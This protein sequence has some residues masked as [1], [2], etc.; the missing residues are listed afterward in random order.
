[1]FD[2]RNIFTDWFSHAGGGEGAA[3][4]NW[5][6]KEKRILVVQ[7]LH[8]I[9]EPFMLRRAGADVYDPNANRRAGGRAAGRG[10]EPAAL[11]PAPGPPCEL[12]GCGLV[13]RAHFP[14]LRLFRHF[15]R[16]RASI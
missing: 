6:E 3:E 11:G 14:L 10:R 1:M 5:V 13:W 7:R 9:L 15:I 12:A 4:D 16:P 2:D 8:Q